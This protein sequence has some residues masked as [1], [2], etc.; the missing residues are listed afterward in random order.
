MT[1]TPEKLR[2]VRGAVWVLPMF[3]ACI[4]TEVRFPR[5][6]DAAREATAGDAS[7]GGDVL[8]ANDVRATDA[9]DASDARR[10][11]TAVDAPCGDGY[12]LCNGVCRDLRHDSRHCGRCNARCAEDADC[13]DGGCECNRRSSA[14]QLVHVCGRCVLAEEAGVPDCPDGVLAC[15]PGAWRCYRP[16]TTAPPALDEDPLIPWNCCEGAAC[17]MLSICNHCHCVTSSKL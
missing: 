14:P 16:S 2:F 13:V 8:D 10:D 5:D 15:S 17:P 6:L 3:T 7:D 12:A 4:A 11:Q 9:V 1:R